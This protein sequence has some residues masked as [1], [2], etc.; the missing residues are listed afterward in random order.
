MPIVQA[1]LQKSSLGSFHLES[2]PQDEGSVNW[3]LAADHPIF[4]I[5]GQP[6]LLSLCSTRKPFDWAS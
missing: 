6:L 1:V 5:S 4:W 3:K 2:M